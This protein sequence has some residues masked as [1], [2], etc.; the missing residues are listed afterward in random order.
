MSSPSET[1][2]L[3]LLITPENEL[4]QTIQAALPAAVTVKRL[5][6]ASEA[7][8]YLASLGDNK[9]LATII[10]LHNPNARRIARNYH[11]LHRSN[12]VAGVPQIAILSTPQ[13]RRFILETGLDDYLL[14]P[15]LPAEINAR[16]EVYFRSSQCL[17]G[18]MAGV[19][20]QL[21]NGIKPGDLWGQNLQALGEIFN[22]PS[23]WAL[24]SEEST[25]ESGQ[26]IILV[27]GYNLPPLLAA[28]EENF[29]SEIAFFFDL[30]QQSGAD[31][32]KQIIGPQLNWL[33]R[34]NANGLTHHL[35]IP[36]HSHKQILGLLVLAYPHLPT[37]SNFARRALTNLGRW[38]GTLLYFQKIYEDSQIYAT[39]NAFLVMIARTI[40]ERLDLSAILSLALEQT[41][42]LLE[43]SGGD[44]W[45]L[46]ADEQWLDLASSLASP[47]ARQKLTRRSAEQG[48]TGWVLKHK[49]S[50][51]AAN[52]INHPHF[53]PQNDHYGDGEAY[54]LLAAPLHHQ[55][56]VIG[57]LSVHRER[58]E[59]F[60]QSDIALLEGISNL[61][62]SAI[63][64]AHL[65]Q[66]L[67]EYA[68]Q[69]QILYEMSQQIALGLD[70]QS[71]L[72][73]AVHWLGRLFDAEVSSLWLV[74]DEGETI[75]LVAA[76]GIELP[77]ERKFALNL[78]QGLAGWAAAN[79][80]AILTNTPNQDPR[81]DGSILNKFHI[82][83]RNAIALPMSY[84][85]QIIGALSLANKKNGD[86]DDADLTLLSTAAEMIALAVG[87]ARLHTQTLAI[88]DE[89]ERLH[90]QVLYAERLATVG[91]LTAS[92]S[93]EI[94]NPMQAIQ[95][96]LNL[97]LEELDSP[98]DLTV[99][100]QLSLV[101]SERVI[102]LLSRMRQIYRPQNDNSERINLNDILQEAIS[103]ANKEF[104]RQKI[105]LRADLNA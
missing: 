10:L 15:L 63:A 52:L 49:Q 78:G 80:Q 102:Q 51:N 74:E 81:H 84:H 17:P 42:P 72:D 87:N 70:L 44:I 93:H 23:G 65:M 54:S 88:M 21:K 29:T 48:L 33:N 25:G 97:A 37:L 73:R 1:T 96:A 75:R 100:L 45:L 59:A 60:T 57:V 20:E 7:E 101:E 24:L 76:L 4:R 3:V 2:T 62:A 77:P 104:R 85:K 47:F 40:N 14:L 103:L 64:N 71:A 82:T 6:D 34:R 5:T 13:D 94:N 66:E 11:R 30:V 89:R 79:D 86:F 69:R 16:L 58:V 32:F 35:I 36:L 28:P 8:S 56:K 12:L 38:L 91:R 46:S 39:Q 50:L 61:S 19:V 41:I 67:R 18:S 22:A 98:E 83:A 27:G 95:G 31:P 105:T 55:G 53:D 99:Y 9:P 92:L 26:K 68:E 43:A 90:H